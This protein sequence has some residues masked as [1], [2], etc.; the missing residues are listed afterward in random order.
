MA[1]KTASPPPA[2][3]TTAEGAAP[4]P[5]SWASRLEDQTLV[6]MVAPLLRW[7]STT[8]HFLKNEDPHLIRL[9]KTTL[10]LVK[11]LKLTLGQPDQEVVDQLLKTCIKKAGGYLLKV[12]KN[13][14]R[15]LRHGE[16]PHCADECIT[17]AASGFRQ[18]ILRRDVSW[19]VLGLALA[20]SKSQYFAG[21][22]DVWLRQTKN[23]NPRTGMRVVEYFVMHYQSIVDCLCAEEWVGV[24]AA[25]T[26]L[27]MLHELGPDRAGRNGV[28]RDTAH[29]A[30]QR[31][32]AR[33]RQCSEDDLKMKFKRNE[34]SLVPIFFNLENL[35]GHAPEREDDVA[36]WFWLEH[37]DL[38]YFGSE[39]LQQRLF[40][41][42]EFA[43]WATERATEAVYADR[44]LREES[45]VAWLNEHG[46][47]DGIFEKERLHVEVVRCAGARALCTWLAQRE[48][49]GVK[50]AFPQARL[51]L[52]WAAA[53]DSPQ[54]TARAILEVMVPC[55]AALPAEMLQAFLVGDAFR[56]A[57]ESDAGR[58]FVVDL[59]AT[60]SKDAN[61]S[62]VTQEETIGPVLRILCDLLWHPCFGF[63]PPEELTA[64]FQM[65]MRYKGAEEFRDALVHQ[66]M[67]YIT[68]KASA[69]E[70][71]A[72]EGKAA[73][74]ALEAGSL[75]RQLAFSLLQAVVRTMDVTE[76][77]KVIDQ[78]EKECEDFLQMLVDELSVFSAG[79]HAD[80][81]AMSEGINGRLKFLALVLTQSRLSL[82]VENIKELHRAASKPRATF[83]WE[84]RLWRWLKHMTG[85]HGGRC[86]SMQATRE[87]FLTLLC[88]SDP[89]E[90]TMSLWYCWEKMFLHVNSKDVTVLEKDILRV[91]QTNLLG[92]DFLWELAVRSCKLDVARKAKGLYLQVLQKLSFPHRSLAAVHAR[93][94]AV[95]ALVDGL[96]GAG[97]DGA[98]AEDVGDHAARSLKML[99]DAMQICPGGQEIRRHGNQGRGHLTRIKVCVLERGVSTVV[100]SRGTKDGT[101]AKNAKNANKDTQ[102]T[103]HSKMTL[104]AVRAQIGAKTGID[105]T[106]LRLTRERTNW[107][108]IKGDH[109]TLGE[110]NILDGQPLYARYSYTRNNTLTTNKYANNTFDSSD[111]DNDSNNGASKQ[112]A[113][114][115]RAMKSSEATTQPPWEFMVSDPRYA[116]IF[117]LFGRLA[118]DSHG[119]DVWT[120]L[121]EMPTQRDLLRQLQS[122]QELREVPWDKWFE[123]ESVDNKRQYTRAVYVMQILDS[124][125]MP[126]EGGDDREATA[127]S[128]RKVFLQCSGFDYII[129]FL[130]CHEGGEVAV[131]SRVGLALSVRLSKFFLLGMLSSRGITVTDDRRSPLLD[132]DSMSASSL[133]KLN[134]A[135]QRLHDRQLDDSS[136]EG[137]PSGDDLS[138]DEGSG[139]ETK[140]GQ[141]HSDI[142]PPKTPTRASKK[143]DSPIL[144][145]VDP[146]APVSPALAMKGSPV[147]GNG[148]SARPAM[149]RSFSVDSADMVNSALESGALLEKLLHIMFREQSTVATGDRTEMLV[150]AVVI[151]EGILRLRKDNITDALRIQAP[152]GSVFY[153]KDADASA[154]DSKTTDAA[155]DSQVVATTVASVLLR[156]RAPR[157]RKILQRL[158][159]Y[160][161]E[162]SPNVFRVVVE[163]LSNTL[164]ELDPLDE[165]A[166][167]TCRE[168][169][170]LSRSLFVKIPKEWESTDQ[171]LSLTSLSKSILDKLN[172]LAARHSSLAPFTGCVRLDKETDKQNVLVGFLRTL[173][174]VLERAPAT[175]KNRLGQDDGD[176]SF[177]GS[178]LEHFLFKIATFEDPT[179]AICTTPNS[180]AA[181]FE[182]LL[183]IA[184]SS[185]E[186][187]SRVLQHTRNFTETVDMKDHA[188][189]FDAENY[190]KSDAGYG[191][192]VNQ[193]NTCYMNATLQQIFMITSLRRGLLS[194]RAPPPKD[195]VAD[196]EAK[197]KEDDK[198]E[199]MR[200]LQ[201]GLAFMSDG[202]FCG[203]NARGLVNACRSLRLSEDVYRQVRRAFCL[204]VF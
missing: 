153:A 109:L 90:A 102:M 92:I 101:N 194:F 65:L 188:W 186:A 155:K 13:A 67:G 118:D 156:E 127:A 94:E 104:G 82:D 131:V 164:S 81:S 54:G 152:A 20:N 128:W 184:T 12:V 182:V 160:M 123:A 176:Q 4:K 35:A 166:A 6:G 75:P 126:A 56:E 175:V 122:P 38:R 51:D 159:T 151:V 105:P 72:A 197:E 204:C 32:M 185:P 134:S 129:N 178:M 149:L 162:S 17:S 193:G 98:L 30:A 29:E 45:Y 83:P 88:S 47:F 157:V 69:A 60:F 135:A 115:G 183:T 195:V 89:R 137:E 169:F 85:G 203:F 200:Q 139:G 73:E 7:V 116:N 201:R 84:D 150:T 119:E 148:R 158:I 103:F 87:T 117:N 91:D 143:G 179:G 172:L 163:M 53:L 41:L 18:L 107:Q 140:A 173:T 14:Y 141:G 40:S 187:L 21:V 62:A 9:N 100:S 46:V 108:G 26:L 111:D 61:I 25:G 199:C 167:M 48:N 191:G 16:D 130:M 10:H 133:E 34:K 28:S 198:M 1:S 43:W 110:L 196:S 77:E 76:T 23:G 125:L 70:G 177:L 49:F 174:C 15:P 63:R 189:S 124:M 106:K 136:D 121:Q 144:R 202:T 86:M 3:P 52:L 22:W 192:L 165:G 79:A 57:C 36:P 64:L 138:P 181:A 80:Q 55:I 37:V 93:T 78:I 27:N 99:R 8:K 71:K 68:G 5:P 42:G 142:E 95:L 190:K 96:A 120:F 11:V 74:A 19:S 112:E 170:D 180:R 114:G 145:P 44:E 132:K 154:A 146:V 2:P 39:N 147:G 161:S 58:P 59:L 31:F 171:A 50:G 33:F 168:F 66:C 113:V 97:R 24:T